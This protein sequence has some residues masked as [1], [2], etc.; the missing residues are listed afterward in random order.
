M[1]PW[2]AVTLGVLLWAAFFPCGSAAGQDGGASLTILQEVAGR[3]ERQDLAG[4]RAMLD[5]ALL[6]HP[7]DPALHNYA[8]V[9]AAQEGAFD[10]AETHFLTAIRLAPQSPPA[11][12]NLGRLYQELSASRPDARRR[13]LDTYARLLAIDPDNVEGLYQRSFLLAL[14][15]AFAEARGLIDRL[16]DAIRE[17]PQ[18]LAVATVTLA[19]TGDTSAA[20]AAADR[21]VA[22]AEL[23][24]ADIRAVLPAFDRI[25]DP[26]VPERLLGRLDA[27]G[28][29]TAE[30][31]ERLG[32][33]HIRQG[34]FAEGRVVLERAVEGGGPAVPLLMELARAAVKMGDRQ[35]ALG[36]LAH[37]R[38][39][40]PA[41]AMVH[42]LFGMVCV[43]ENLGAEAYESLRKAVALA[44]D[45]ALMNYAMGAVAI[46]RR[47]PSESIPY[48][49][50]YVQL[51][52][53]DVRGRFAL[54][55]A[56]FH[57]KQFDQARV[58]LEEA[59]RH[60]ETAAGAHYFLGRIARERHDYDTARREIE[61]SLRA[62]AGSAD[63][64][65]ELGR[66]QTR[67]GEYA[68]AEQSLTRALAI[69][70]NHYVATVNLTALYT[71][72][73]DARRDEYSRRLAALEEARA[74][75]AQDFLRIVEVVP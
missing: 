24:A 45:H 2:A 69:D 75:R 27:R 4:A 54:G 70:A 9:V 66:I 17:R 61:A 7:S 47:D 74:A 35:G 20:L 38:S 12:E 50:K 42:F 28:E 13:A 26:A 33:L 51:A 11:Y 71:R 39:R 18:V 15:G 68:E 49:E 60:P 62:D 21:L 29:A 32:R 41:N 19:G 58:D 10:A 30:E 3:L 52:P 65:A 40:E 64:W 63:A 16:P 46:T 36:Y 55:A 48:F 22:H 67:A 53:E 34:R 8:G 6:Q 72:T 23:T 43:E 44:P 37:A 73:R 56:R 31:L 5:T 57:S 59:A 14:D 25:E 1:R